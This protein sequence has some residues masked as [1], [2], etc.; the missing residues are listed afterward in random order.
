MR[1]KILFAAAWT[2]LILAATLTPEDWLKSHDEPETPAV[3]VPYLDK[4]IHL[5]LFAVGGFLWAWAVAP[6]ERAGAIL[7]GG[8]AL[9]IVTELGQSLP[10]VDRSTDPMDGLAD[11]LG[12]GLGLAAFRLLQTRASKPPSQDV[13]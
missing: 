5:S 13:S 3:E 2:L 10:A 7:A 8:L 9:A 1:F 11:L 6:R 4:F 12:L